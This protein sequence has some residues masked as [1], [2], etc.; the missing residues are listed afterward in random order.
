MALVGQL[1]FFPS[2]FVGFRTGTVGL[3][4]QLQVFPPT[5]QRSIITVTSVIGHIFQLEFDELSSNSE[6]W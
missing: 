5:K 3:D 2:G 6:S 1:V 4:L